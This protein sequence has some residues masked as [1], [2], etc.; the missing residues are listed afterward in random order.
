MVKADDG[1]DIMLAN[2]FR[3][4]SDSRTAVQSG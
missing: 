1:M 2:L 3:K 4:Y